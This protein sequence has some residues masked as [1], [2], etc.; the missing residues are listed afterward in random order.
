MSTFMYEMVQLSQILQFAGHNS[1][2]LI[3]E[4]GRGTSVQ[5]GFALSIAVI[6]ELLGK[7]V[8]CVFVTHLFDVVYYLLSRSELVSQIKFFKM[9]SEV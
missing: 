3:D 5:D 8:K 2:V 1:L 9:V 6:N 7:K 4:L